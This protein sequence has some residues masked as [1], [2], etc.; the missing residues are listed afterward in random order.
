[1]V[2]GV[3]QELE[4]RTRI[5]DQLVS[6]LLL[7]LLIF[8]LTGIAGLDY[9]YHWD[10]PKLLES[11]RVSVYEGVYLPTFYNYPSMSHNLGILSALPEILSNI[12]RNHL[13]E[14]VFHGHIAAYQLDNHIITL[15]TRLVF[16]MVSSLTIVWV[17]GLM[18]VWRGSVWLALFSS[19]IVAFS[20]E[21][22]Y[23]ARWIA[24][25][26]ILMQFGALFLLCL[27]QAYRYPQRNSWLW[28]SVVVAGL[29]TGTKYPAGLLLLPALVLIYLHTRS[30]IALIK[31]LFVFSI[32][33]LI[34]T[35][36]TVLQP[37]KFWHNVEFE[38]WHYSFGH[39]KHTVSAG[40][41]HLLKNIDY[42]TTVQHSHFP[43]IAAVLFGLSLIGVVALWRES[44]RL[45]AL[46]L[47]FPLLYLLF[48]SVQKA[49]LIRNLLIL[50]PFIAMYAGI[51]VS[52]LWDNLR[53]SWMRGVL[54]LSLVV[55][56]GI[57]ALWL[58]YSAD[59]I[60][61]RH[62]NH[63]LTDLRKW[64]TQ[65]PELTYYATTQVLTALSDEIPLNITS[66][67]SMADE[68]LVYLKE[69]QEVDPMPANIPRLFITQFGS[70]EANIDYYTWHGD[71]KIVL[72]P[73]D[74][75]QSL[76]LSDYLQ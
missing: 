6:P 24:P 69:I 10:E 15:R 20:W 72:I 45:T 38:M 39:S 11:V 49:M 2:E 19:S 52:G 29:A 66:D 44:R 7:P 41:E 33:Y 57:N 36:G 17:Y 21:V 37:F 46:T 5:R 3:S 40:L 13:N 68:V 65:S 32:T 23:H 64:I 51:G 59:T 55:I 60:T 31:A 22:A 63:Y 16:L 48:I 28:S 35:P 61:N 54:V 18:L 25:D 73:I 4:R 43:V 30:R 74:T 62:S 12:D 14:P 76:K 70:W 42:L 71:D 27:I 58:I 50:V 34:T 75:I 47:L 67:L 53:K 1:M 8:W 56:L 26:T 9:G